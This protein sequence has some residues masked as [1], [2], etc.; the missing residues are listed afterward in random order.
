MNVFKEVVRGRTQRRYV[1]IIA[2][3]SGSK[4]A[5]IID[6]TLR[7]DETSSDEKHPVNGHL[8]ILFHKVTFMKHIGMMQ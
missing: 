3:K 5:R 7:Y 2:F 1:D 6:P 8:Y 4:E